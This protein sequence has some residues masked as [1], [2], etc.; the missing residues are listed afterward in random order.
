MITNWCSYK[1]KTEEPLQPAKP[2]ARPA[3]MPRNAHLWD[4]EPLLI[5]FKSPYL[6]ETWDID[7]EQILHW[8][9]KWRHEK[10]NHIPSFEL[11][12]ENDKPDIVIELNSM[13][14][15]V[16]SVT[17]LFKSPIFSGGGNSSSLCG[18]TNADT[19]MWLDLSQ[20]D[21]RYKE[22]I[23]VHEFGHALG[24][25]H[26]HQRSDFCKCVDPYLDK[27]KMKKDLGARFSDWEKDF[28]LDDR[29]GEATAYDSHS[30]MH[31]WLVSLIIIMHCTE[32][33]NIL[34]IYRFKTEWLTHGCDKKENIEKNSVLSEKQKTAL[35]GI[36]RRAGKVPIVPSKKDLDFLNK[37]YGGGED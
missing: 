23:V 20:G 24:L 32:F 19:T 7:A 21:H 9:R 5:K 18:K 29:E 27:S 15:L 6:L 25:G 3:V 26:E 13:F 12:K 33:E 37:K 4:H 1:N 35:I 16:E 22:H 36:H 34:Y 17:L 30:V 11:A 10:S 8:A 28:N 14:C 2:G 31:Y